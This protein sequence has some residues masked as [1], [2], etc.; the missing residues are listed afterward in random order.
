MSEEANIAG[1]C[2]SKDLSPSLTLE[3]E[4]LIAMLW[5]AVEGDTKLRWTSYTVNEV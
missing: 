5:S 4:L 3:A 2:W 1:E